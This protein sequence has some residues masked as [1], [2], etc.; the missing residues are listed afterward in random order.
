ML[1][2]NKNRQ[3]IFF[4]ASKQT[5]VPRERFVSRRTE[6]TS[7]VNTLTK[8]RIISTTQGRTASERAGSQP[9]EVATHRLTSQPGDVNAG[10]NARPCC[11][12][13]SLALRDRDSDT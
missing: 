4:T 6:L 12:T 2:V 13:R 10:I 5:K 11:D 1:R 9:V 7:S 8:Q 3:A